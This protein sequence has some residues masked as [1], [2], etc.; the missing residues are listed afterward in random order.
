[1]DRT[2]DM[3]RV[4]GWTFFPSTVWLRS[5]Y[6]LESPWQT[7]VYRAVHPLRVCWL[8]AKHLA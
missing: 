7:S 4:L 2:V 8:A 3:L 6:D 1:M 5:H